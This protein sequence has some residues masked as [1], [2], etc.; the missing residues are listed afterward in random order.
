MALLVG[1]APQTT[2]TA[3]VLAFHCQ[4]P[5]RLTHSNVRDVHVTYATR[6]VAII[7]SALAGNLAWLSKV[8]APSATFTVF[9][10]DSG[11]GPRSTGAEAAIEFAKQVEPRRYQFW[12]ASAGPVSV[13]PCRST[14]TQLILIRDQPSEALIATFKYEGGILTEVQGSQ[15]DLVDGEFRRTG[16]R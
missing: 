1:G 11:I 10:A 16:R 2:V 12:T 3:N 15:V 14:T 6:S 5:Q 7:R 9:Q 8:V 4:T 13:D